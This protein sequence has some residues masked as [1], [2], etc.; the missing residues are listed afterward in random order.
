MSYDAVGVADW[1]ILPSELYV[2][3]FGPIR[4]GRIVFGDFT[5]ICGRQNTGKT[6]L[7]LLTFALTEALARVV[8][9]IDSAIVE[10]IREFYGEG[11]YSR[12][13][14]LRVVHDKLEDVRRKVHSEVSS[15]ILS[16]I[17]CAVR[18]VL[19]L[20]LQGTVRSGCSELEISFSTKVCVSY[21]KE[22]TEVP[23]VGLRFYLSKS[24]GPGLEQL[25]IPDELILA[26]AHTIEE[27]EVARR[28]WGIRYRLARAD[29][30]SKLTYIPAERIG[31][32]TSLYSIVDSLIRLYGLR[33]FSPETARLMEETFSL[34]SKPILFKFFRRLMEVSRSVRSR[35]YDLPIS[36]QVSLNWLEFSAMPIIEYHDVERQVKLP[37]ALSPSGVVQLAP[38]AIVLESACRHFVVLE[39]PEIN[40][41]PDAHLRVAEWLVEFYGRGNVLMYLITTHSPFLLGKLALLYAKGEIR[42]LRAYLIQD[43]DTI[44]ELSIARERGEIELPQSIVNTY[45]ELARESLELA[46]LELPET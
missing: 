46:G 25:N 17:D 32:M 8:H 35:T 5:I 18:E 38:V 27:L 42:N 10:S 15:R 37:L 2:R 24:S 45:G 1:S 14:V 23:G 26:V 13:F 3:N 16:L 33:Q 12:D 21:G 36:G 4:E 9:V 34:V 28:G 19:G 31:A 7:A 44:R 22:G 43:D 20:S 29:M 11:I 6:Y 41:H 40:L 39:E 30:T